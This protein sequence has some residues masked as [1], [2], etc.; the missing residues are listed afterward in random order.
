VRPSK[1]TALPAGRKRTAECEIF[2][3]KFPRAGAQTEIL[4]RQNFESREIFL[5]GA[6]DKKS[7]LLGIFLVRVRDGGMFFQ[8]KK[9]LSQGREILRVTTS[10]IF[11]TT[12]KQKLRLA[13]FL[14]MLLYL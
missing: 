12:R 10:K 8:Q 2:S 7:R 1:Q 14:F 11:L 6:H 9:Q 3:R 5:L 4:R 13:E